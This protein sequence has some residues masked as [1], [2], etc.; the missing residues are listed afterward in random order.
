ME[1]ALEV[2]DVISTQFGE[3]SLRESVQ[4]GNDPAPPKYIP[5]YRRD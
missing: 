5:P 2:G 3:A 4:A 1:R